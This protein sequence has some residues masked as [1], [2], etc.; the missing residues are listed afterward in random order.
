ME[1][2]SITL[3]TTLGELIQNVSG[4]DDFNTIGTILELADGTE[5]S[6]FGV[7]AIRE[8]AKELFDVINEAYGGDE[9][10]VDYLEYMDNL[11]TVLASDAT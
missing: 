9:G 7:I 6:V 5:V 10:P 3:G 2:S 8:E 1:A 11:R 4:N